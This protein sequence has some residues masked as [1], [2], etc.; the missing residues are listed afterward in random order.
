M[1]GRIYA[2]IFENVA[3]SATQDLFELTPADDKPVRIH[4]LN[5]SNVG[6][7]GDAGDAS[8]EFYRLTITRGHTTGGSGGTAPTP[9]PLDPNGPAAGFVSEVNNT[10][11]ATAG[12]TTVPF[13]DGM[14]S[15]IPYEKQWAPEDQI[16]A[17]QGN[18]TIVV[19]LEAAPADAINLSGTL[20]VE[21]L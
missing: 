19:R 18:T 15:R 1:P 11:K 20:L 2:V 9:T 12:T 17:S 13:S 10:T 16:Q 3:V 7:T 6:G 4:S 5:L 8:E 14:N 21:E